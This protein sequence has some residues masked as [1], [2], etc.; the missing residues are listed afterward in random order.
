MG[1]PYI[2]ENMRNVHE[3]WIFLFSVAGLG[4]NLQLPRIKQEIAG[5]ASFSTASVITDDHDSL[6]AIDYGGTHSFSVLEAL[7]S[8]SGDTAGRLA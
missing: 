2:F 6:P 4:C 5:E 3:Y 8:R 7:Q 1:T